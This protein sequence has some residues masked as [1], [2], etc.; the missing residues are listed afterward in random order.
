MGH[1][2]GFVPF[3]LFIFLWR[4]SYGNI[5]SC[6]KHMSLFQQL[7]AMC[8]LWNNTSPLRLVVC[9]F[10]MKVVS[11]FRN[12]Y[13]SRYKFFNEVTQ[14]LCKS[15][16]VIGKCFQTKILSVW[17]VK[18]MCEV[19]SWGEQT[20]VCVRR[21]LFWFDENFAGYWVTVVLRNGIPVVAVVF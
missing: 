20:V 15:V 16:S 1:T 6:V 18:I 13:H 5:I 21:I 17:L 12:A 2:V 14:L 7:S 19:W 3:P 8:L 11:V 4:M 9:G 10:H